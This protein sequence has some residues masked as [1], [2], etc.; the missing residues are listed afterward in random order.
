MEVARVNLPVGFLIWIMIIPMLTKIDFS[1]LHQV[2]A[3]WKGIVITVLVNWAVKPFSMAL[4]AWVFVRHLFAPCC[5]P[6]NWTVT[7]QV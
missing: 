3:H 4:L 7:L 6:S 5:Q 1:A 2:R